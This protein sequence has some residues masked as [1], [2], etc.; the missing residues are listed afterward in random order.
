M[1]SASSATPAHHQ[2]LYEQIVDAMN[3]VFGAYPG[4]RAAHAKGVVCEGTFTPSESAATLSRA[5]HFRS[6][7]IP[8]TVRFSDGTGIPAIPDPDPNADPR[9]LALRFHLP[10]GVETDIVS[11]S[12]NGFPVGTAEEFLGMFQ[13]IAATR[14]DSPKPTPIEAFLG[15]HPRALAF[16]TTPKPAPKSFA[17]E[18]FYAV[19]AFRFTNR[20]GTS[21]YARYQIHPQEGE[22]HLT[23][24]ET[25]GKPANYLFDELASRLERGPAKFNLV[26]QLAA[27]NDPIQ[28]ASVVWPA[29]RPQ[30]ALGV[31]TVTK[32]RADSDAL[33]RK[34]IFDPIHLVDGIELSADPLPQAR[35]AIYSIS[36]ERRNR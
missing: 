16:V 36:Y 32:R 6:G 17:T 23:A 8:M 24:E 18:S 12:F 11:H 28:D 5:A 33:Q 1:A 15:G 4:Y 22:A 20:E 34:L 21:R 14:P 7:T 31:I 19:N 26:A 3:A 2:R 27:A 10:G 25:A 9:G 30:V 35:S 13:A 29:D